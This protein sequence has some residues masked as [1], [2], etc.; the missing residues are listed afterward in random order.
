[1][2]IDSIEIVEDSTKDSVPPGIL[3]PNGAITGLVYAKSGDST[4]QVPITMYM[5]GTSRITKPGIDGRFYFHSIPEGT[6]QLRMSI[7]GD[8]EYITVVCVVT[9]QTVDLDS[10]WAFLELKKEGYLN[11][12]DVSALLSP[13]DTVTINLIT[14]LNPI[15]SNLPRYNL[16]NKL[17]ITPKLCRY[18][19]GYI[20][21]GGVNEINFRQLIS[22]GLQD[23]LEALLTKP[24]PVILLVKNV[25]AFKRYFAV[26]GGGF[27][28]VV[29]T[30]ESEND[31]VYIGL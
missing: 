17:M 1:V 6:Y 21:S 23:Q 16:A 8:D 22:I 4:I 27:W 18:R 25:T 2:F 15:V 24:V 28:G 20:Y 26:N 12:S 9:G 7:N 14:Y 29:L 30:A 3:K 11:L 10:I 5:P 19:D 13:Q 31:L